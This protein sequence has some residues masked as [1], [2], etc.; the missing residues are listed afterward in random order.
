MGYIRKGASL[1]RDVDASQA[2]SGQP[3]GSCAPSRA[4]SAA[5]GLNLGKMSRQVVLHHEN[6]SLRVT[7]PTKALARPLAK[8]GAA[9]ASATEHDDVKTV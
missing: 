7:V 5:C 6:F 1:R 9:A 3:H 4:R 2:A 8:L